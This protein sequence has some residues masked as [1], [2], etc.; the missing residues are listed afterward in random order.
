MDRLV[1]F[2]HKCLIPARRIKNGKFHNILRLCV[3]LLTKNTIHQPGQVLG[4]FEH[5]FI[6]RRAPSYQRKV[7]FYLVLYSFIKYCHI[8][9]YCLLCKNYLF[10]YSIAMLCLIN[11]AFISFCPHFNLAKQNTD[12]NNCQKEYKGIWNFRKSEYTALYYCFVI[13]TESKIRIIT[14]I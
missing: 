1:L 7:K 3:E 4:I 13:G 6:R 8:L 14:I 11:S 9:F 12:A 2:S 10:N 5:S